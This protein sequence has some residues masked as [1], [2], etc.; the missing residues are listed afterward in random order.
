MRRS[1]TP[2]P[3]CAPPLFAWSEDYELVTDV[4]ITPTASLTGRRFAIR[5]PARDAVF[6][7]HLQAV[8]NRCDHAPPAD[9]GDELDE[10]RLVGTQLT[11]ACRPALLAHHAVVH[12]IICCGEHC[13]LHRTKPVVGL[14]IPHTEQVVGTHPEALGDA[15]VLCPFVVG[16]GEPTDSHDRELA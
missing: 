15:P 11:L 4:S 2:P 7:R 14:P 8:Q 13:P 16:G 9:R 10:Q 3:A 5:R 6:Q 1:G 12:H